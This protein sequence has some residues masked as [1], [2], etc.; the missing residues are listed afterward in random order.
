MLDKSL[1]YKNI[2][3]K[4]NA[5]Q[6]LEIEQPT[7]PE[8]YT[9]RNY[10]E[11]DALHWARI[12]SSVLE[13]DCVENAFDYFVRDYIPY[14]DELRRRC[15]F[16]VNPEGLPV[17]TATAW[18][19]QSIL[20]YQ[21][22]LHW[23]SVYPEYQGHGLGRAIVSKAMALFPILDPFQDVYLHTQTWSHVAVGLYHSLG[24][25]MLKKDSVAIQNNDGHGPVIPPNDYDEAMAILAQVMS[26]NMIRDLI[27]T[28]R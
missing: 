3:M 5:N 7:L 21:P 12:E 26:P 17:G 9:F 16:V 8:G 14:S 20:G 19:A 11:G 24:F 23:V 27:R 22:S 15:V 25:Y 6:I 10:Q 18:F 4:I 28:A 1:P 2:I 13:F